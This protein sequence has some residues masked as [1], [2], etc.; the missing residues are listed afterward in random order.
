MSLNLCRLAAV[1]SCVGY[2][3]YKLKQR[4]DSDLLQN[5]CTGVVGE[6]ELSIRQPVRITFINGM[7]NSL[8]YCK[9]TAAYISQVHGNVNVHYVADPTKGALSDLGEAVLLDAAQA[10]TE[11]VQRLVSLWRKLF[12]EMD[13]WSEVKGSIVH[14]AHSKGGMVTAA[15]LK[16]LTS[17]ERRRLV[18][19][20]IG[21]PTVIPYEENG[22]RV[23]HH[24]S[25]ADMVPNFT[26]TSITHPFKSLIN[27]IRGKKNPVIRS[28]P[29]LQ[30]G[31][32]LK[33]LLADHAILDLTYKQLLEDLGRAFLLE[34]HTKSPS[35]K[36]KSLPFYESF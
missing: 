23:I 27:S 1:S 21:S 6:R 14:Y 18:I 34:Y 20:V 12:G 10:N 19:H 30:K 15:A 11:S 13:G 22:A 36:H 3:L 8:D 5:A 25:E 9:T 31:F 29:T 4:M 17:E 33:R 7:L 2:S 32:G 16:Q 24:N 28:I 26:I 35:E